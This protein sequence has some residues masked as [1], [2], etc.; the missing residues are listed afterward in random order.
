MGIS[1]KTFMKDSSLLVAAGSAAKL[2]NFLLLPLYTGVLSPAVYG[3]TDT[4]LNLSALLVRI[5]ALCM[6]WG[7]RAFFYDEEGADWQKTVT[8]S[9]LIFFLY[10]SALCLGLIFF[11][12]SFSRILFKNPDYAYI[13]ALGIILTAVELLIVPLQTSTR[14]RGHIKTVGLFSFMQ[15]VI[16]I[17]CTLVCIFVFNLDLAAIVTSVLAANLMASVFY[18]VNNRGYVFRQSVDFTLTKKLLKY[19]LPVAPTVLLVWVNNVSDR[20]VIGYFFSQDEVG[21]YG[22]GARIAGFLTV[23]SGA[24]IMA[25]APFASSNANDESSRPKYRQVFDLAVMLYSVI[26]FVVSAFSKEIIQI[27]TAPAYHEAYSAVTFLIYGA[28]L[29]TL[30]L[31]VGYART[32]RKKGQYFSI[33]LGAGAAVNLGLNFWLVPI[34]G[35]VAAA[36]TTLISYF[37]VFFLS[38]AHS[39]HIFP[40]GYD[41]KRAAAV[42]LT[43]VPVVYFGVLDLA[44]PAKLFMCVVFMAFV[45]TVYLSRVQEVFKAFKSFRGRQS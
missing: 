42:L 6:D 31:L 2:A 24:V 40:C 7:M 20:Y 22:I 39:E 4:I 17:V 45:A 18:A 37:I 44:V 1:V 12:A 34:Y 21:L 32:I 36:V 16:T 35:Y 30:Q 5:F 33:F 14:M 10:S 43:P 38:S 15:A 9:G 23:I 41:F 13:V 19:S 11:S 8:S 3:V 27:M 29:H 28:A 25:Y 26:C